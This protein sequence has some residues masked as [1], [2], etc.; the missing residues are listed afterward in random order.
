MNTL[1]AFW[2][3]VGNY[4][5]GILRIVTRPY[6]ETSGNLKYSKNHFLNFVDLTG[7]YLIA[8]YGTN[9]NETPTRL[10]YPPYY[11]AFQSGLQGQFLRVKHMMFLHFSVK[12]K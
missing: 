9:V 8:N 11:W 3:I 7:M 5:Q 6:N 4:K 10:D 1:K 2:E 12:I